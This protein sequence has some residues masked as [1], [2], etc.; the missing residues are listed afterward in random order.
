MIG[1][2]LGYLLGAVVPG[3]DPA[4]GALL[5][6]AA[7]MA[8]AMRAPLTSAMFAVELT[9][10]FTALVPLL[11]ACGC[12][13][14]V[15]VL[16]LKRSILTEKIARR[17]HHILQEYGVDPFDIVRAKDIMTATVETLPAAM[18]V[19]EAIA[20]FGRA[21]SVHKGYPVVDA[22]GRVIGIM[23]RADALSWADDEDLAA[24][25]LAEALSDAGLVVGHPEDLVGHL[26]DRMTESDTGRIPIVEP[27]SGK[28][29]GLVSRRDLLRARA[30]GRLAERDRAA[31]LLR[32][33]APAVR[34]PSELGR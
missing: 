6:M 30:Q 7:M 28:L 31:Y 19:K 14:A 9:G 21:N 23:T 22:A 13:Y 34:V 4:F 11:A 5:G 24:I 8:G 29:L 33:T 3:I 16:L 17:G 25:P 18:P 10:N 32:R 1:G 26:A 2:A 20:F 12:G 27:A 15:T